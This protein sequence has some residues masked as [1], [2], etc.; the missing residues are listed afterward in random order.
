LKGLNSGNTGAASNDTLIVKLLLVILKRCAIS[1]LLLLSGG[2]PPVASTDPVPEVRVST[3]CVNTSSA[4]QMKGPQA[5]V[6][7]PYVIELP[8]VLEIRNTSADAAA[9]PPVPV[10]L[11]PRT[12][13]STRIP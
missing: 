7:A 5:V 13:W 3:T 6:R 2:F 9:G 10:M 11:V 12:N 4:K 1:P 8:V